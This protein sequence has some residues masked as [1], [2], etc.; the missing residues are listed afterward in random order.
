MKFSINIYHYTKYN[1]NQPKGEILKT[2]RKLYHF[3]NADANADCSTI[4]LPELR[5]D[6]LKRSSSSI[7]TIRI[8]MGKNSAQVNYKLLPEQ[9]R[10]TGIIVIVVELWFDNISIMSKRCLQ[11]CRTF[12]Q[13]QILKLRSCSSYQQHCHRGIRQLIYSAGLV[14]RAPQRF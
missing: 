2:F 7:Y 12:A 10:P 6:E 3:A 1:L 13:R 5:S 11:I 14:G 8:Q 4:A 9:I